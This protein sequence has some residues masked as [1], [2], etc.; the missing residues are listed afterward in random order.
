MLEHGCI[1]LMSRHSG[2][3]IVRA[4]SIKKRGWRYIQ[5]FFVLYK[6]WLENVD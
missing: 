6:S 3:S 1:R 2:F 5:N 4:P